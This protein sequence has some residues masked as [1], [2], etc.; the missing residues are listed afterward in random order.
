MT[1]RARYPRAATEAAWAESFRGPPLGVRLSNPLNIERGLWHHRQDVAWRGRH[2]AQT[3]PRFVTYLEPVYGFRAAGRIMMNYT[4]L[5]AIRTI[6]GIVA[7]WAPESDG[8]DVSGYIQ[9]VEAACRIPAARELTFA[10]F[11]AVLLG[12]A[13]VECGTGHPFALEQAEDGWHLANA[14][15]SKQ[16]RLVRA[17]EALE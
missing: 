1:D 8:N 9:Q 4:R 2:P 15:S 6:G 11:P 12:M 10:E 5:Y 14:K 7:R 13:R 16:A 3:H 17:S